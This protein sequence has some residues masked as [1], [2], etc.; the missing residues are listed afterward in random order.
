MSTKL[1]LRMQELYESGFKFVEEA[2]L[3]EHES[4]NLSAVNLYEKAIL[5]F[6][7]LALVESVDKRELLNGRIKEF[8]EKIVHLKQISRIPDY[9][10]VPNHAPSPSSP[11]PTAT[12]SFVVDTKPTS[13]FSMAAIQ[14][15]Q[16]AKALFDNAE[17]LQRNGRNKSDIINAFMQAA[18]A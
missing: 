13:D 5:A 12:R 1:Q 18:D 6:Q 3:K 17:K 2:I 9:P 8:R 4:D 10:A 16:K 15:L 11:P 7:R 14:E